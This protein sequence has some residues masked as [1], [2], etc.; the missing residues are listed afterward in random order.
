[1][2][3]WLKSRF[4]MS[5]L[6]LCGQ[7]ALLTSLKPCRLVATGNGFLEAETALGAAAGEMKARHGG[8]TWGPRVVGWPFMSF[9][10][11]KYVEI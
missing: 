9:G 1:M 8:S 5:F 4:L 7:E 11:L 6:H 2:F 3:S 10:L